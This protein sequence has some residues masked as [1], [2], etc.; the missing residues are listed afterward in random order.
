MRK[1]G[2]VVAN[3]M[4]ALGAILGAVMFCG[5]VLC[6]FTPHKQNIISSPTSLST[7]QMTF[8]FVKTLI[9]QKH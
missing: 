8:T 3:V 1:I 2:N 6:M 9:V 4:T 7:G 5:C